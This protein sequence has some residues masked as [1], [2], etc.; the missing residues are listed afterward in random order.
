MSEAVQLALLFMSQIEGQGVPSG[1][2]VPTWGWITIVVALAGTVATLGGLFKGAKNET[3][4]AKDETIQR[5]DAERERTK[6][7][8]E[9]LTA[10]LERAIS[11]FNSSTVS[12]GQLADKHDQL[13]EE[14]K[15]L[16]VRVNG[17]GECTAKLEGARQS[18]EQLVRM[19]EDPDSKFSTVK[20]VALPEQIAVLGAHLDALL[21]EIRRGQ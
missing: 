7:A 16:K 20:L 13:I 2:P 10:L 19:H 12:A 8:N 15:E 21:A 1:P 17:I 11:A 5:A 3:I 6:E 4:L 9:K 18:I 14:L